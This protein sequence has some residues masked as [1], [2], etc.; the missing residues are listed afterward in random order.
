[1]S[2]TSEQIEAINLAVHDA[3]TTLNTP[4]EVVYP[5]PENVQI[6]R[7]FL[8]TEGVPQNNWSSA[9]IWQS[10]FTECRSRGLLVERPPKKTREELQRERRAADAQAGRQKYIKPSDTSSK[11][12]LQQIR[13]NVEATQAA[14]EA[15]RTNRQT[16]EQQAVERQQE[17]LRALPLD[18]AYQ[19][20]PPENQKLYRSLTAEN[21]K[22]FNKKQAE[23]AHR[24][25][26]PE[27]YSG[28]RD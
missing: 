21:M 11:N 20:M 5:T 10:A 13:D 1:M 8:L 25:K 7:R 19:N 16:A 18:A 28:R 15:D 4:T 12:F 14:N 2:L 26:Y 23:F 6:V 22:A 3:L 9:F 17:I 27:A 24:Q